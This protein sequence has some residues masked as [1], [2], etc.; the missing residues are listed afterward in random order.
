MK[1]LS[2]CLFMCLCVSICM[3]PYL[4]FEQGDRFSRNLVST[5]RQCMPP[6]THT[7]NFLHSVITNMWVRELVWTT[8][9][10][11]QLSLAS[12]LISN[13]QSLPNNKCTI[14]LVLSCWEITYLTVTLS[15]SESPPSP[16]VNVSSLE[17][18]PCLDDVSCKPNIKTLSKNRFQQTS[19]VTNWLNS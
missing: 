14:I 5:L 7:F 15:S 9:P 8:I 11:I 3:W 16:S 12:C 13:Q 1:M 18:S 4:T 19:Q 6:Q 10:A 2:V 17:S